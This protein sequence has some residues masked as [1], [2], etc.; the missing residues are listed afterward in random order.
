MQGT[1]A[2]AESLAGGGRAS[3]PGNTA[4]GLG[5]MAGSHGS[6]LQCGEGEE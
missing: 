6:V 4:Q 3:A 5:F 1:K 2:K